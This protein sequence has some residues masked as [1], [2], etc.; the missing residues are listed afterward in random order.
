MTSA[1]RSTGRGWPRCRERRH[2]SRLQNNHW[3]PLQ[4]VGYVP[5]RSRRKLFTRSP[6]LPIQWTLR[7]LPGSTKSGVK[8]HCYVA[9]RY[10][11]PMDEGFLATDEA[12]AAFRARFEDG[13][14]PVAEFRHMHHLAIAVCYIAEDPE[15]MD[16]LRTS[17]RSYNLSQG[18]K[19]TEDSGY[20]ETITRFWIEIVGR[21]MATLPGGLPRCEIAQLVVRRFAS[22]RDLFH[23]WYDFDVLKSREARA[24]WVAPSKPLPELQPSSPRHPSS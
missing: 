15:P 23:A 11:G 4:A 9:H 14:W 19:N 10:N 8:F 3:V 12:L 16:R 5:E 6:L 13:T 1:P 20:H 18:C 22:E 7:G 24:S 21:Y 17:I 2:R